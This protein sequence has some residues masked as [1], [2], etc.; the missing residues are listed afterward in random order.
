MKLLL[1]SNLS[2]QLVKALSTRF[3][4][5]AHVCE[6][7]LGPDDEAIW[8]FA[9]ANGFT[10]ISK[11]SDFYYRSVSRGAPPKVVWLRVGNA[12]TAAISALIHAKLAEFDR[13]DRDAFASFLLLK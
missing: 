3:P 9:T 4:G 8:R 6:H 11:D 5:T 10:I 2:P 7:R 13:F 1:D 12:G